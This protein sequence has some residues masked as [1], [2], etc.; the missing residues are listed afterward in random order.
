MARVVVRLMLVL[1]VVTTGSALACSKVDSIT[2]C[3]PS[4]GVTPSCGF[5]NPEDLAWLPGNAWIAVSQYSVGGEPGSLVAHRLSDQRTVELFPLA[6]EES[7]LSSDAPSEGWG[8]SDC[9]GPPERS[10]FSPH[11]IDIDLAARET[12]ALAVV[13]HGG[14][15]SIELFEIGFALG[16]P[17]L[18]WRGCIVLPDGVMANDVAFLPERGLVVTN[19][20]PPPEGVAALGSVVRMALG[21]NTGS[22]LVWR[23]A[24]GWSEV[25]GSQGS[26]PNGVAVSRDGREIYFT[27]WS[28]RRLVWISLSDE[29]RR[30]QVDLAFMPDNITWSRDGRLL[31]AGQVARLGEVLACGQLEDGTCALPFSVVVADPVSLDTRVVIDHDATAT[32]AASVALDVGGEIVIG[33]FAGDRIARA[34]FPD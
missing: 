6:P 24:E 16:A 30:R 22:I 11:G 33:T 23:S 21:R 25:A 2:G 8:A 15:E 5:H 1:A 13:N 9:P 20:M 3:E 17:A 12:P 14:R 18:G 19:M 27:E 4:A 10:V 26:A 31:V 29:A 28:G 7:D 34:D 32:G